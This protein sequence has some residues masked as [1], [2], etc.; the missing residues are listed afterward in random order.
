LRLAWRLGSYRHKRIAVLKCNLEICARLLE[1]IENQNALIAKLV[2][3][4]FEQ[5]AFIDELMKDNI[6]DVI[7][8]SE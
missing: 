8:L 4:N 7:Q 5:S 2:N 6:E 1:I 3:E